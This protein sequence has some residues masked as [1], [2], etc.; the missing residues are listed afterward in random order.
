MSRN[1]SAEARIP[2]PPERLNLATDL[3]DR[4]LEAGRGAR[5]ALRYRG[6]TLTYADVAAEANR[7]GNALRTL[8]V[9]LE[10][11]VAIALPDSPEFVAVFLGAIKIGAVALPLNTLLSPSEYAY[12]LADSGAKVLIADTAVYARIAEVRRELH[13]LRHVIV[14]GDGDGALSY[15]GVVRAASA[16]LSPADTTKDDMCFWQ[17]SSGTTGAPKAAVHLHHDLYLTARLYGEHVLGLTAHD[18]TFSMSKLFFSYGL[19]NSLA[20]PFTAGACAVLVPER[21]DPP[22]AFA[23]IASERPTILFGVPT[24]YAAMLAAADAGDADLASVRVCISAGEALPAPIFARWRERFGLEILD[25]IGSTEVGYIFISNTPGA[26]RAGTSGR[27]LPGYEA[28]IVDVDDGVGDLWVKGDS[29]MAQ[30]WRQHEPTKRALQGE[31]IVTGD[32]YSVDAD[33]FFTYAGRSDDMLRVGA[34]WVSPIE[35]EGVLLD[36]PGVLECAVVGRA[37][38]DGLTRPV[39]FVVPKGASAG[40]RELAESLDALARDRLAAHKRPRWIEFRAGLP[41]TATGKIQRFRLRSAQEV[42]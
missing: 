40:T 9:D 4:H 41:K 25:G 24:A 15:E 18:R 17:Y 39:A 32:R 36:H 1:A 21:A 8:G 3:L 7:V 22:L 27:V 31:W 42:G 26:A 23:T 2:A 33:G 28:K 11:R 34:Q 5:P 6:R 14:V 29:T 20:L 30:Y 16:E 10:Q 12:Q 13:R 37:D 38:E 35:V 19:S